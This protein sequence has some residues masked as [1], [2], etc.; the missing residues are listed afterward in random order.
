[1][2]NKLTLCL[3][4]FVKIAGGK[5]LF[6]GLLGVIVATAVSFYS[7]YHYHGLLHFGPAPNDAWWCYVV[8]HL[9]VWLVPA[10]LFY[11]GGL[12]LSTSRIRIVDVFGTVAFAQLP[13]I[14]MNLF[15]LL[16]PMQQLKTFDFDLPPSQ[17]LNQPG[18]LVS[19]WFSLIS[20]IFL[21]WVLVWMYNALK[22]SCNLKGTK[23]GVLY[24]IAIIGGDVLCRMI[25]RLCY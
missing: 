24:T 20:I 22:V 11:I 8:E 4:P 15:T 2:D 5:A 6:W 21:V 18:L 17:L 3:N 14:L 19:I 10:L 23:L 7:G 9:V 13:F 16:P 12:L 25:I 1:M